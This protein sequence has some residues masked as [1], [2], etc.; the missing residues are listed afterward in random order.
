M[1][2]RV[3]HNRAWQPGKLQRR[4]DEAP[5]HMADEEAARIPWPQLL[6]A[7]QSY[8][9][10]QE[11]LLWARAIEESE[12]CL[13]EWLACV[14]K[15]RCPGFEQFLS[16]QRIEERRWPQPVWYHLEQWISE[17]IFAKSRREGWMNAVGYYAVRDLAAERNDAY[18]YYCEWQWKRSKPAAYPSFQKWRKASE[19][20]SDEVLDH[21]ET[22]NKLLDLIRL[23]R[24]VSPRTLN[25]TVDRYV[26]WLVFAYWVH[27]VLD[28]E[29]GLPDPVKRELQRRCPGFLET[30]VMSDGSEGTDAEVY[31]DRLLRWMEEQTF[32]RPCEEGWWPVLVYQAR[33]HPR[34]QRLQDV[35][36]HHQRI[37]L[38]R[39]Q[40]PSFEEW[41]PFIDCYTFEPADA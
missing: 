33:L 13:P 12:R 20:C 34:R 28:W 41:T 2:S 14:V 15:K 19:H 5:C 40:S 9:K 1:L 23:S 8:V 21:F 29:D 4:I 6:K 18:W 17:R 39:Q 37:R 24:R 10:W 31:L 16:Q 25:Q 7:R 27:T 11:F 3:N 30:V 38:N 32:T 36:R 22:T 26:E 35:W